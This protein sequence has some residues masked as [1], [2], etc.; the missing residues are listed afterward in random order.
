MRKPPNPLLLAASIAF[1]L[2]FL[3]LALFNHS[4]AAT[5]SKVAS[6][7][8]LLAIALLTR[9]AFHALSFGL[10]ISAIGDFLLELNHLGPLGPDQLFLFGLIA[11]LAAHVSY[12][13]LFSSNR[14]VADTTT[15]RRLAIIAITVATVAILT[16]LWPSLGPMRIPVIVYAVALATMAITAQKSMLAGLV[17][18]GAVLFV[19]SDSMLAW[20]HFRAPIKFA[21]PFIWFSYYFAQFLITIGVLAH[22]HE[23]DRNPRS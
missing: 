12:I 18:L 9:P 11:F 13:V 23:L 5:F 10:A 6:I 4:A 1:S 16:R 3:P 19:A 8:A 17:A 2:A 15:L 7:V 21:G 22:G 14:S 20:T